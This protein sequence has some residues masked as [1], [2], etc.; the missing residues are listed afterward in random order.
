MWRIQRPLCLRD[1]SFLGCTLQQA[2]VVTDLAGW[3][4]AEEILP[5][6]AEAY[7]LHQLPV[8]RKACLWRSDAGKIGIRQ[9]V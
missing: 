8:A 4:E 1:P 9:K 3:I 7:P 6:G 2:N 5:V